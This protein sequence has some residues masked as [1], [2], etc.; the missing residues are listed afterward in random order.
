MDRVAPWHEV[1]FLLANNP[2]HKGVRATYDRE[3]K[4]ESF[5]RVHEGHLRPTYFLVLNISLEHR[6]LP[7][8]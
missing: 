2:S 8:Q 3:P 6:S 1:R 5:V 7:A 4:A